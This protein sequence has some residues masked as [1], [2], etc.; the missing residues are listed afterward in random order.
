MASHLDFEGVYDKTARYMVYNWSPEDFSQ[1]FGEESVY[2]SDT[3]VTTKPAYIITLKAGE[4]RE[5]GQFEAYTITKHFV[6]REIIRTAEGLVG[7]ERERIE[8]SVNNADIREP[9]EQKTLQKIED[10]QE[11]SFIAQLR[12]KIRAEEVAKLQKEVPV[13]PEK[14]VET[15]EIKIEEVIE[16]ATAEFSE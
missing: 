10:G 7:R 4:M 16:P 12:D 13:T 11:T 5:F 14:V 2:N 3:V 6:D 8:M 15:V 9:F 1:R